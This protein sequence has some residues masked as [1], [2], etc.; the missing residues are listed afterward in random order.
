MKAVYTLLF[1]ALSFSS[2]S[3]GSAEDLT[4]AISGKISDRNNQEQLAGAEIRLEGTNIVTYSDL[5]GNFNLG[6]IQP[7]KHKLIVKFISYQDF[8]ID[9]SAEKFQELKIEIDRK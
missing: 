3:I 6:K 9:L 4:M 7:G 1:V 5:D 2:F 8:V